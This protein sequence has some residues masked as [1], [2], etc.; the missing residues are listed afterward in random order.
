MHCNTLQHTATHCNTLQ[1]AFEKR[2]AM[3]SDCPPGTRSHCNALQRAATR[4]DA[5]QH[6]AT[7]C[8]LPLK[9]DL[10]C[11]RIV[12][13]YT[14]AVCCSVLHVQRMFTC[15]HSLQHNVMH[16]QTLQHT[17]TNWNSQQ[18]AFE[19]QPAI[20]LDCRCNTLL[21]A[22]TQCNTLSD[23]PTHRIA[24]QHTAPHCN[25]LQHTATHSNMPCK[26]T[27]DAFRLRCS[28]LQCIAPCCTV[29]HRVAPC[30]SVLQCVAVCCSV[31]HR[32]APC[33]AVLQC[34]AVC[35]VYS[36]VLQC[37]AVCRSV[38]QCVA[39]PLD[40]LQSTSFQYQNL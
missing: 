16:C 30:C 33:C 17:A 36:S 40:L 2:P 21:R 20:P 4:C 34:V 31:L 39:T 12:R 29:L 9:S 22:A 1:L 38:L 7:N 19:Q 28:V 11:P 24:S 14:F 5:L 32:V 26:A 37:V 6:T 27:C 35:C 25:T 18:H 15:K 23:T 10:R 13:L 3:P 8:N